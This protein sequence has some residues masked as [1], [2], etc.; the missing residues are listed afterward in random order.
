MCEFAHRGVIVSKR[1]ETRITSALRCLDE[2]AVKRAAKETRYVGEVSVAG[3]IER[4]E[5]VQVKVRHGEN[6][7]HY[8]VDLATGIL[9]SMASGLCLSSSRLQLVG[10]PKP[11]R[12][13]ARRAAA[14]K[15]G[16]DWMGRRRELAAEGD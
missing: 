14:A 5:L 8:W 11:R 16:R 6:E 10:L 2:S 15:S 3:T 13:P 4:R 9:F 12:R 1:Q 7:T